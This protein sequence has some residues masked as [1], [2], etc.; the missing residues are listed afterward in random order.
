MAYLAYALI[1]HWLWYD[2]IT[3]K[4]PEIIKYR[5]TRV[6]FGASPSQFLLNSIIKLRAEQ[7]NEINPDFSNKIL[8]RFYVDDLSCSVNSYEEGLELNFTVRK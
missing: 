7:Y 5:F 2:D 8:Y 6:M 1:R 3:V 4:Y